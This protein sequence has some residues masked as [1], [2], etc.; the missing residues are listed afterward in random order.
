MTRQ[1]LAD[2]DAVTGRLVADTDA[3]AARLE[4]VEAQDRKHAARQIEIGARKP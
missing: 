4:A 1:H 3:L 2:L